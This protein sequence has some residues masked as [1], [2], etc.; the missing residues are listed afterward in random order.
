M[1]KL[2]RDPN[3]VMKGSSSTRIT[4]RGRGMGWGVREQQPG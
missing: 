3:K 1:D 4:G 2:E